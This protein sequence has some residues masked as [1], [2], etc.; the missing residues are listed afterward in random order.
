VS[1]DGDGGGGLHDQNGGLSA[2]GDDDLTAPFRA[3]FSC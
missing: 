1:V 2:H 3:L